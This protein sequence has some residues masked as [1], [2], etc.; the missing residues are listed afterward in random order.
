MRRV[1]VVD[2]HAPSRAHVVTTLKQSRYE[3]VGEAATGKLALV[4]A[5][6]TR[7]EVMLMAVGLPDID[8]MRPLAS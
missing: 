2:D 8:G 1:L 3:L 5:R 4:I 6:T 7:P